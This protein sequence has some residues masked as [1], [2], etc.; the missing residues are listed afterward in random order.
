MN[1][2]DIRTVVSEVV[3]AHF[4]SFATELHARLDK[5]FE[6]VNNSFNLVNKDIAQISKRLDAFE[7][8]FAIID[9]K[10]AVIDKQFDRVI[11][12]IGNIVEGQSRKDQF[13]EE[14]LCALE[15][16]MSAVKT[17]LGL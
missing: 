17:N 7:S 1:I 2:D 12:L 15:N 3:S 14:R 16:D 10:F 11:T 6:G 8:R 5:Q 4:H 9:E 13:T